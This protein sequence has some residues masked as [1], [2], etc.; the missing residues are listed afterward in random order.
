MRCSRRGRRPDP[1]FII[2]DILL[3]PVKGF[4]WLVRELH[5]AAEQQQASDREA[6]MRELQSLHMRLEAGDLDEAEFEQRE[7]ELLDAIDAIDGTLEEMAGAEEDD[8]DEN[9]EEEDA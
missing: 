9:D 4:M 5:N 1:V 8:G 6:L 7:A 3:S 2:D